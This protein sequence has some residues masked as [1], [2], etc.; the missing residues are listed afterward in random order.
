MNRLLYPLLFLSLITVDGCSS[1]RRQQ[2]QLEQQISQ[3]KQQGQKQLQQL[4]QQSRPHF[5]VHRGLWFSKQAIALPTLRLPAQFNRSIGLASTTPLS[6]NT[7]SKLVHKLCGLPVI[8][9]PDAL[10]KLKKAA[11]NPELLIEGVRWQGN[12]EGLL[13]TVTAALGISWKYSANSITFYYLDSRTFQI[14][15]IPSET[16]MRST[17]QS[18]IDLGR[19]SES[20]SNQEQG[21]SAQAT[22][23]SIKSSLV[24]DIHRNIQSML[25]PQVGKMSSATSTGAI[26]VTDTPDVLERVAHYIRHENRTIT[27]QV[28]LNIKLLSVLLNDTNQLGIDWKLIHNATGGAWFKGVNAA[29]NTDGTA[30]KIL[31]GQGNG[32]EAL[33]QALAKQGKVSMVTSPSV[34]TLNLQPVPVQVATQQSYLARVEITKSKGEHSIS[35]QPGMITHGFNM[36]LLPFVMADDQLLLQYTINLSELIGIKTLTAD[37]DKGCRI[38]LPE[39][40]SRLFSQKVKLRSNETLILSGF[41]QMKRSVNRQGLGSPDH[42]VLGGKLRTERAHQ[43]IMLMITPVII[44]STCP[45]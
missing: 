17:I 8:L 1:T 13:D 44:E 25:T 18:G 6:M 20:N 7:F 24:Q 27:K 41:E 38:Q 29:V 26:T 32:S 36:S 22:S 19:S 39:I 33:L 35:L 14:Y 10:V 34:T 5:V 16:E 30:I 3:Q 11:N 23:V 9:T 40:N 45:R 21:S 12:L 2:Q 31:S 42:W 37:G 4:Q 28:L 43:I 15:A